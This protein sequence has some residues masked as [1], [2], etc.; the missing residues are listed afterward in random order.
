MKQA[1]ID[2][3]S[4][5]IRLTL[6]EI[7][8]EGFRILFKE[9]RMTGLASYV[10]DGKLTQDGMERACWALAD[11][12][13]ILDS[14]E[15]TNVRI[16]ATASLRNIDNG[17]EAVEAIRNDPDCGF[18]VE[19][20]TGMEEAF[21]GYIGA[22]YEAQL[23]DG[24][25]MDV[26]GASTEIV[27]FE[28]GKPLEMASFHVGALNLFKNCVKNIIPSKQGLK[29]I[30][31]EIENQIDDEKQF[32]FGPRS[33]LVCVGGTSRAIL[34]LAQKKFGLPYTEKSLPVEKFEEL[35][36]FMTS[37]SKEAVDLILKLEPDRIHTLI[38]GI[39]IV[40]HICEEFQAKELVVCKY[41]VREGYLCQKILKNIPTHKTGS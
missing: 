15:I 39:M 35:Y 14:L 29:R 24:A 37:G 18:D 25:F 12:R 27:A 30:E 9:K 8:E 38:P 2:I 20:I 17:K 40:H 41:G 7:Q 13:S 5:S 4:N 32:N 3:G 11:F 23:R 34:K 21:Y 19:I 1:I 26:G 28:D 16:F 36:E 6:Y 33:P 10:E 31:K 22:M